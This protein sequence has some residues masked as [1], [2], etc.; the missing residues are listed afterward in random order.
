METGT[1]VF[2]LRNALVNSLPVKFGRET[3][4]LALSAVLK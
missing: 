2:N 4:C 3:Q 1:M